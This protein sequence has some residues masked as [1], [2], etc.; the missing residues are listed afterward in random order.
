MA[1]P[2][3]LYCEVMVTPYLGGFL[4]LNTNG[5]PL[6][7]IKDVGGGSSWG[8]DI[9][10]TGLMEENFEVADNGIGPLPALANTPWFGDLDPALARCTHAM[11]HV[12]AK[13]E[14]GCGREG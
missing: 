9:I 14:L 5:N 11:V 3:L 2:Y 7:N 12:Y 8:M 6:P 10:M 1:L 13:R 4:V